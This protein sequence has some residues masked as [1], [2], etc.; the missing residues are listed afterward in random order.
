MANLL[1][2]LGGAA[3][4]V[5]NTIQH[6]VVQPY[7]RDI[8]AP[9]QRAVNSA[10]V[11]GF[12]NAD[13][14]IVNAPA[15]LVKT[16][17][18][19]ITGNNIARQNAI[20]NLLPAFHTAQT[21]AR[22]VPEALN[23]V[24][25]PFTQ[26]T[27]QPTGL[28][29]TA[30]GST[31]IQNIQKKVATN[32]NAHPNLN[33]LLRVGLAGAEG[34]GSVLQDAPV[35]GGA[36]KLA[37]GV[38]KVDKGLSTAI[39]ATQKLG[40][41]SLGMAT[42]K[43][44]AV[45]KNV[46]NPA[47]LLTAQE[48]TAG[49]ALG[50]NDTKILQAKNSV[51]LQKAF[52]NLASSTS[53]EDMAAL[54]PNEQMAVSNVLKH[55]GQQTSGIPSSVAKGGELPPVKP[56]SAFT[57]LLTPKKDIPLKMGG[58]GAKISQAIN[59]VEATKTALRSKWMSQLPTYQKLSKADAATAWDIK[60]GTTTAKGASP[61]VLKAVKELQNVTPQVAK[62][63]FDQGAL[64]GNRGATYMPHSY[65]FKALS[66]G[67][68]NDAVLQHLMDTQQVDH[69]TATQLFNDMAKENAA[70][71]NRFGNFENAR[72][73]DMPGYSKS[74]SAFYD[75][76]QGAATKT[77]EA[78][79]FGLDN[80]IITKHL[81]NLR[82]EGGNSDI[83]AKTIENYLRSQDKGLGASSLRATRG[84]W[85]A[86]S[87]SKAAISH[88]G[89]LSNTAVEAGIGRTLK[90]TAIR[91]T[92]GG[93]DLIRKSGV[94]NPQE[95]HGYKDQYTATG[96]VLSKVTAP[97]MNKVM[98]FNRGSSALTGPDFANS[99]LKKGNIPKVR[100]LGVTG[101]L[102]SKLTPAQEIQAA[103][104]LTK[105][106]MFGASRAE[107]PLYAETKTGK[108]V[109]QARTA[110]A[111]RQARFIKDQVINEA[112]KGNYMPA[113]RYGTLSAGVGYGTV[114]I[115][116]KLSGNKEGPG[117]KALDVAG[118]LG[119]IPG[120]LLVQGARYGP[121]DVTKFVAD[122]VAPL[123]GEAVT[124]AEN[125]QKALGKGHPLAPLGR[126]GLSHLP[127]VGGL[128][129]KAL[130]PSKTAPSAATNTSASGATATTPA[131]IPANSA[132]AKK[133]ST[134]IVDNLKNSA[135]LG[136]QGIQ[137]L[138]DGK[139]AAQLSDGTVS[140]SSSLKDTQLAVAK[141]T[142]AQSGA[143]SKI[144]YTNAG[145]FVLQT[146][147]AGTVTATPKLK[148]DYQI[149]TATLT[150][151]KAAGD[152][153][154]YLSTAQSQLKN[155]QTQLKDSG[156]SPLEQLTLQNE[157][158]TLQNNINK[159]TGYGGFTKPKS[160]SSR[161]ASTKAITAKF[162]VGNTKAPKLPSIKVAKAKAFRA[163][164]T[165]KISVS[166]IPSNYLS[167]KLA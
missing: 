51:G 36:L 99:L 65:D 88:A 58:S 93:K 8:V 27:Y 139:F 55:M 159:Y 80:G 14:S 135:Q 140:T 102:G 144:A 89:Q 104:G 101:E 136:Q 130:L 162:N 26:H 3:S 60:E 84:L 44:G 107:T 154:G 35:A 70:R 54:K 76:L 20:N 158:T 64:V 7:Q 142:F 138:P 57:Q 9:V 78:K 150:Q 128:V 132:Q 112:R 87:L 62:A 127:L 151:Q 50:L 143:S 109:G 11:Q 67:A 86:G 56:V 10:P 85:A 165:S 141:D 155:I 23:T 137:K 6:D 116:N 164:K 160:G 4:R 22:T 134:T 95:L 59:N 82:I 119:G 25:H 63:G 145:P 61:N 83:A 153:N 41:G 21:I 149:G 129:S 97:G 91:A 148:Y 111:Y 156:T 5:N 103:R 66:K 33:P 122:Q 13:R 18:A 100:S 126:Q 115:K 48:R 17:A 19:D 28:A 125:A 79:H 2:W 94:T 96:K 124:T 147:E 163:P 113:L 53:P 166:K 43:V 117:G 52:G 73:T 40:V 114:G 123:A 157:A 152:V 92:G 167:R 106:T 34:A 75:Y 71:P 81:D 77:A 46:V 45:G 37:K 30:F 68:K 31:P 15:N 29:A 118:A 90:N 110:F 133:Q 16:G 12:I 74:Q 98:K 39:P 24:G 42:K 131:S 69:K 38:G 146:S 1:S 121:R 120:E 32:Y 47:K 105:D 108:V 72:L 49:H 161:V